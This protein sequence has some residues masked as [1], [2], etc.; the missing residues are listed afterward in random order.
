MKDF[1]NKIE[2]VNK[3]CRIITVIFVM[4]YTP[5]GMYLPLNASLDLG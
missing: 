4:L 2:I 3:I 5:K 1:N